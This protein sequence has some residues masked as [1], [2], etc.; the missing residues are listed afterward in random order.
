MNHVAQQPN[1]AVLDN[2]DMC[3]YDVGVEMS[4]SRRPLGTFAAG[5]AGSHLMYPDIVL[6][7]ML[8]NIQYY[9]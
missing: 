4:T 7:L 1:V 9:V 2:E 3:H 5:D 8:V 6:K